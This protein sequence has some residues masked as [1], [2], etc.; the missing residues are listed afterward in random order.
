M[1]ARRVLINGRILS[2]SQVETVQGILYEGIFKTFSEHFEVV[3]ELAHKVD[4]SNPQKVNVQ[5]VVDIMIIHPKDIV[6]ICAQNTE[7]DFAVKCEYRW[8]KM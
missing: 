1:Y 7:P 2:R 8:W 3:L 5:E 6:Y 4:T